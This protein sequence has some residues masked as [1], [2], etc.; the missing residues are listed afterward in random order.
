MRAERGGRHTTRRR[1]E[2][3][4]AA[5]FGFYDEPDDIQWQ[6]G[7]GALNPARTTGVDASNPVAWGRAVTKSRWEEERWCY[8]ATTV[9]C[10]GRQRQGRPRQSGCGRSGGRRPRGRGI[11]F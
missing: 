5:R 11:F 6:R 7:V 4:V 3:R 8:R 1:G 9:T 10:G 2:L